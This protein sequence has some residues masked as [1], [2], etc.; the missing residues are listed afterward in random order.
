MARTNKKYTPEFKIEVIETKIRENLSTN[1]AA[2]RFNLYTTINDYKCPANKRIRDWERIY[3]ERTYN[4]SNFQS[5]RRNLRDD[6][7]VNKKE[8]KL[9]Q[10]TKPMKNTNTTT[11]RY[12]NERKFC[13]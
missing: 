4:I 8:P 11:T 13:Y 5:E 1:E 7:P 10:I 9:P 3:L 12:W 2:I 6:R